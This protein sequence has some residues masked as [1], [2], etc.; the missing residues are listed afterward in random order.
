MINYFEEFPRVKY[1]YSINKN[2]MKVD[3]NSD[4]VDISVRFKIVEKLLES[5]TSYYEYYWK[6]HDRVDI[7][8]DKYYGDSNLAW[9]VL[10]SAEAFDWMY[11]LPMTELL[12][13]KYLQSKYK[14]DNVNILRNKIH[15]YEDIS[16]TVIDK[17]NYD[18][19]ED[20]NKISISIYEYEENINE[21]K[22]NIKLIS[23][24]H[25][26]SILNEFSDRLQD[27]KN[28]RALFK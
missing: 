2:G 23:K 7:V 26:K 22:R 25:L 27:I 17:I 9:L 19:L 6:D 1:P 14:V 18:E 24:V 21:K 16:G 8:A 10:L 3:T 11:D 28:N 4:S 5:H 12:F 13:E 15:H 20:Y